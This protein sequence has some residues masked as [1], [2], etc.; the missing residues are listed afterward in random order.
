MFRKLLI[1][2]AGVCVSAV[3]SSAAVF[4]GTFAFTSATNNC[5]ANGLS[6]TA[7]YRPQV[8]ASE[9]KSGLVVGLYRQGVGFSRTTN[10]QF[11]GAG[12]FAGVVLTPLA[13]VVQLGGTF[14]ITQVPATITAAT[15]AVTLTGTFTPTTPP[16]ICRYAFKATFLRRPGT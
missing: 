15:Q 9:Q 3:A 5:G 4:D 1:A 2:L 13:T 7:I 8:T 16:N 12:T 10:G 6:Y 11:S 14:S